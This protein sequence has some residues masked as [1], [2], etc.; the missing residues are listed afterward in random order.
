MKRIL[1][2]MVA[3]SVTACAVALA[4]VQTDYD[5]AID[6]SKYHTYTWGNVQAKDSLWADR[7]RQSVDQQLQAKGWQLVSSQ[8]GDVSVLG[9]GDSKTEQEEQTFYSGGG[10][11]GPGV[12]TTSTYSERKG[13]VIIAIFDNKTKKLVW[14]GTSTGGLADKPEKNVGKLNKAVAKMFAKF[15]PAK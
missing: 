10:W 13:L 12:A 9:L 6:F 7:I 3:I 1:S 5:H 11:F 15:P 8:G 2:V 14:R 4:S